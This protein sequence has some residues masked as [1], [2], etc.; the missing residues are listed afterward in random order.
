M[1]RSAILR[2]MTNNESIMEPSSNYCFDYRPSTSGN[3][4]APVTPSSQSGLQWIPLENEKSISA[5]ETPIN[6]FHCSGL[7]I[8]SSQASPYVPDVPPRASIYSSSQASSFHSGLS[9]TLPLPK[10]R[11]IDHL[12]HVSTDGRSVYGSSSVEA[13]ATLQ[14]KKVGSISAEDMD[15]KRFQPISKPTASV[16][17][18]KNTDDEI[19]R[20]HSTGSRGQIIENKGQVIQP[21][22]RPPLS[23]SSSSVTSTSYTSIY[24]KSSAASSSDIV[25]QL[26]TRS[27]DG[28]NKKP[29][30]TTTTQ[31]ISS[32]GGYITGSIYGGSGK[33]DDSKCFSSIYAPRPESA[34]TLTNSTSMTPV[35]LLSSPSNIARYSEENRSATG[36]MENT[37]D[38]LSIKQQISSQY[39]SLVNGVSMPAT[40]GSSSL[41]RPFEYNSEQRTGVRISSTNGTV[42]NGNDV[43]MSHSTQESLAQNNSSYAYPKESYH[44][45]IPADHKHLS[46]DVNQNYSM[47]GTTASIYLP[48]VSQPLAIPRPQN[49]SMQSTVQAQVLG[50]STS[51]FTKIQGYGGKE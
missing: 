16:Y 21:S 38:I 13:Y 1:T 10:K 26:G 41:S 28:I 36:I 48:E 3:H 20:Q 35:S 4:T 5:P 42:C 50:R 37:N 40:S 32:Q 27:Q 6:A 15:S 47:S 29:E 49:S 8:N 25:N 22:Q 30:I 44:K 34:A 11:N 43:S 45:G 7:A 46:R 14:H 23:A 39:H 33:T 12:D 31:S 9:A 24:K 51:E 19:D 2:E 17:E 18:R